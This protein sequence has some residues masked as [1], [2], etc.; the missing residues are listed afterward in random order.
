[1]KLKNLKN[2]YTTVEQSKRLVEYFGLLVDTADL[3]QIYVA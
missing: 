2:N 1:M 3:M